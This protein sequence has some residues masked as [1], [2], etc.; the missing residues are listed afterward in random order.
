[1]HKCNYNQCVLNAWIV[2]VLAVFQKAVFSW[3]KRGSVMTFSRKIV[4]ATAIAFWWRDF[5]LLVRSSHFD[6]GKHRA[7][8][9]PV[10]VC[11]CFCGSFAMFGGEV[12][13]LHHPSYNHPVLFHKKARSWS[14]RALSFIM[15]CWWLFGRLLQIF[16]YSVSS[17]VLWSEQNLQLITSFTIRHG[18]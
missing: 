6:P 10:D 12:R 7:H 16:N 14:M 11:A 3:K 5:S 18:C 15:Y 8:S 4:R 2:R 9:T 1:M 13:F 17:G